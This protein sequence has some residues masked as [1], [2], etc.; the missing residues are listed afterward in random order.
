MTATEVGGN[1]SFAVPPSCTAAIK[2]A[3]MSTAPRQLQ[4]GGATLLALCVNTQQQGS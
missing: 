2:L 1:H 4:Q 3:W